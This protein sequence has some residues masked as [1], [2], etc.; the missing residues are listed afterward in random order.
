MTPSFVIKQHWMTP[1]LS[2]WPLGQPPLGASSVVGT[3]PGAF[4]VKMTEARF[5]L[6]GSSL[7]HQGANTWPPGDTGG[8]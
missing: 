6:Q 1:E 7:A 2:P 4:D 5:L 3:V 8:S